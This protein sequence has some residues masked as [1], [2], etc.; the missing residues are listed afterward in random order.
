MLTYG[1]S[2]EV[3]TRSDGTLW[4]R[5]RVPSIHGA[6]NQKDYAGKMIRNYVLDKDLPW[7]QSVQLPTEP[8][9]EDTLVLASMNNSNNDFIVI[10]IMKSGGDAQ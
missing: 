6:D 3:N 2:K 4:I 7:F 8:K 5:V 9:S 10:G 1:I